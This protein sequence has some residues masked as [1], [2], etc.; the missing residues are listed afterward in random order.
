M[1][2]PAAG[3][4]HGGP[5]KRTGLLKFND[6]GESGGDVQYGCML[7]SWTEC[8]SVGSSNSCS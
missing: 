6:I 8:R 7:Q 2:P 4:S 3:A 1:G 5:A